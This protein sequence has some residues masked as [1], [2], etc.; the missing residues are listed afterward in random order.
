M[1]RSILPYQIK[2]KNI[3]LPLKQW[4]A[5]RIALLE[6]IDPAHVAFLKVEPKQ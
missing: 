2:V 3:D 5:V 6:I 1:V 4:A